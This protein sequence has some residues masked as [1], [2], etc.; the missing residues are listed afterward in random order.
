VTDEDRI[1]WISLAL[2]IACGPLVRVGPGAGTLTVKKDKDRGQPTRVIVLDDDR[3][4][5]DDDQVGT[6]QE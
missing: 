3:D 4:D 5:R 1:R 2:G 6:R